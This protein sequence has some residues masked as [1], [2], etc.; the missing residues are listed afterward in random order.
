M[1]LGPGGVLSNLAVSS[2][3][4]PAQSRD[5]GAWVAQV[6]RTQVCCLTSVTF[7]CRSRVLVATFANEVFANELWLTLQGLFCWGGFL[8]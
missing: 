3:F 5:V 8:P 4:V 2:V 6:G 7:L 1:E